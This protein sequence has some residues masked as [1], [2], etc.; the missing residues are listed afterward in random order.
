MVT[1][2]IWTWCGCRLR[3]L[4]NTYVLKKNKKNCEA[5]G[6]LHV[7]FVTVVRKWVHGNP[8]C[9]ILLL[10]QWWEK[11][12]QLWHVCF[13]FF[14]V[15]K[16]PIYQASI[17]ALIFSPTGF[18]I[19]FTSTNNRLYFGIWTLQCAPLQWR[20][21]GIL[22]R[23][24]PRICQRV[25]PWPIGS[26]QAVE[27]FQK[28]SWKLATEEVTDGLSVQTCAWTDL[29]GNMTILQL[30]L[31]CNLGGNGFASPGASNCAALIWCRL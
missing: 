5:D 14:F 16:A 28:T 25:R 13:L 11:K 8:K 21:S 22:P 1:I 2:H 4:G 19:L 10:M 26:P 12:K 31:A 24:P 7:L 20:P 9:I 15:F 29:K 6:E 18:N 27:S 17:F 23:P 30:P 3:N